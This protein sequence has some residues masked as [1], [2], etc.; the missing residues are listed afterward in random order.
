VEIKPLPQHM[1]EEPEDMD[2]QPLVDEDPHDLP[3]VRMQWQNFERLNLRLAERVDRLSDAQ[4]FGL[5]GQKQDGIDFAGTA[6]SGPWGYQVRRLRRRPTGASVRRAFGEF[7]RLRPL[8]AEGFIL[9]AAREA[10][11]KDVVEAVADLRRKHPGVHIEVRGAE[12]LA[13]LLAEHPDLVEKF[14]NKQYRDRIRGGTALERPAPLDQLTA[15]AVLRGPH[16]VA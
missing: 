2:D 1:S 9:C 8:D 12:R 7:W 4:A 14:F 5:P 15:D 11:G 13:Q 10:N 16:Q 3:F 6:A